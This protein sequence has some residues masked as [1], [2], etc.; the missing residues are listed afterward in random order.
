MR[1]VTCS[2]E[3]YYREKCNNEQPKKEHLA[4]CTGY[5][6][7]MRINLSEKGV[8]IVKSF[9]PKHNHGTVTPSKRK[10]L[11]SQRDMSD[12]QK[13]NADIDDSAGLKPKQ[14]YDLLAKQASGRKHLCFSLTDYKNYLR[15]KLVEQFLWKE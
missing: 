9:D 14:T 8:Y 12:A 2:K 6:A 4:V 15:L 1:T 11:R 13:A 10:F 5:K 7:H 3:G